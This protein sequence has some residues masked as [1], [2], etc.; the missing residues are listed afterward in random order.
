MDVEKARLA[1]RAWAWADE[2]T[3]RRVEAATITVGQLAE[4]LK[5]LPQDAKLGVEGCDCHG[6]CSG[7][8]LEGNGTVLLTRLD[9]SVQRVDSDDYD[10]SKDEER[11]KAEGE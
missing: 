5:T 3:E 4:I 11:P 7:V 2:E 9:E 1:A 6:R 10:E 8:S